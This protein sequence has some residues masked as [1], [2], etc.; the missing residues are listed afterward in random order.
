MGARA[1]R[2]GRAG[3]HIPIAVTA[4]AARRL[5]DDTTG[6][7]VR[8]GDVLRRALH[9][10][11]GDPSFWAVQASVVA[12]TIAHLLLD[13]SGLVNSSALASLPVAVLFVP[14]AYA[15]LRYG[16]HG[17]AAT[18]VWATLLWLPDLAF[19]HHHGDPAT[20]A[21]SLLL[22]DTVAL[23]VGQRIE[24]EQLA[25][26]TA[27]IASSGRH[28]S[29]AR[30]RQLFAATRAPILLFD[31]DGRVLDANPAA[32][33]IFGS[34]VLEQTLQKV[35]GLSAAAVVGGGSGR[36]ELVVNGQP[37]E[38]R[39]LSSVA[40]S[41]EGTQ[42]QLLLQDVTVERRAWRDAQD[43]AATLLGAHE[44]ERSALAREL[45]DDPLQRLVDVARRLEL[46]GTQTQLPPAATGRLAEAR[47]E[48]LDT[49]RRLRDIARGLRP[50]ALDRLGLVAALQGLLADEED[51]AG[52]SP[53]LDLHL[54]GAERRLEPDC[55][56]C[57]YRIAQEAVHNALTH[58][59][60]AQVVLDLVYEE[61]L[62]RLSVRDDGPGF[63]PE[64]VPAGSH[65]GLRGMRERAGLLGGTFSVE[66]APSSGTLV[67]ATLPLRPARPAEVGAVSPGA[68]VRQPP[69]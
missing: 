53:R 5:G 41:Q 61:S 66:S 31:T 19:P 51:H 33:A 26:A 39:Y 55:E 18:A 7:A 40:T 13:G 35:L 37:A 58:G 21:I 42:L 29:E 64:H 46:L 17:S 25:R 38:F 23:I 56:L 1:P 47:Q 65:L 67:T 4:G 2:G 8:A 68:P 49:A 22:I 14:V 43:Y 20:D 60:P 45:H 59:H 10:P 24:R 27:S 69:G 32:W 16:L 3:H 9:P 28:A 44:E 63:D 57:L 52:G 48:V 50:P 36:V 15:A 34:S 62:V 12:L 30:Y 54:H 6:S 11:L